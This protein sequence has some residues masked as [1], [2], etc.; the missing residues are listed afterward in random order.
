MISFLIK[1]YS[2]L[3]NI[4]IMKMKLFIGCYKMETYYFDWLVK[5]YAND[6][7]FITNFTKID[8][9]LPKLYVGV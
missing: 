5:N 4:M 2:I 3:K 7:K 1:H 6:K 9:N 8:T